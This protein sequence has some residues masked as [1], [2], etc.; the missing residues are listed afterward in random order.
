[1][2]YWI[3]LMILLLIVEVFSQMVWSVCLAIG[4]AVAAFVAAA[5][6]SLTWQVASMA[7]ASVPALLILFPIIKRLQRNRHGSYSARTGMEA[8]IG[9]HAI[10]TD[11]IRPGRMGRA[12]I[13][14]DY[15]Q[16][17]V[18]SATETIHAGTEL[19]ILSYDSIVLTARPLSASEHPLKP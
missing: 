18:P 15:W 13:D 14:G 1:M 6:G 16:V 19:I 9:R 17:V 10:V 2:I 8:L 3:I 11:E 12:R 4:C 7:I 5:G